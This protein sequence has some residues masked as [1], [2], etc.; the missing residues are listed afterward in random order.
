MN[1]LANYY[2]KNIRL[3]PIRETIDYIKKKYAKKDFTEGEKI[4]ELS[5]LAHLKGKEQDLCARGV[6]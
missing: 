5:R 4:E 1:R 6:D 3:I 2:N